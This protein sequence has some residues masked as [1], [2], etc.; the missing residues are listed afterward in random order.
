MSNDEER[1]HLLA[2]PIALNQRDEEINLVASGVRDI[3]DIF[4]DLSSIVMEQGGLIDHIEGNV[5]ETATHLTNADDQLISA[6]NSQSR[7]QKCMLW[8]C[9]ILS[10]LVTI[11]VI[12]FLIRL[13]PWSG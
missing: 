1:Q 12:I 7:R 11:L 13:H 3:N 9:L 6:S 8:L 2:D 10:I 4:K 5:G